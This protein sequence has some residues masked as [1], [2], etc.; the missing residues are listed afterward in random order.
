LSTSAH[1]SVRLLHIVENMHDQAVENWIFRIMRD[2]RSEHPEFHW[3]FY[4][5]LGKPGRLDD[6]VRALGGEVILSPVP[7]SRKW[8]FMSS[9]R[10]TML[11]GS[12]DVVHAHHDI[13]SA[14]YLA[15]SLGTPVKRRIVH[16]HNTS[17]SLPTPS[18]WK[19][20]LVRE[21]MRRTVL[22]AADTIAG[23][24]KDALA[25]MILDAPPRAGR[26]IVV[27]YG[28]DTAKFRRPKRSPGETRAQIHVPQD[29]R[30]ILFA[31]RM[32]EYKNPA[33]VVAMLDAVAAAMPDVIAV[34]AGVGLETDTVARRA[35][36]AGLSDRI[37]LLGW[38]D[39]IAELMLTAD[40]L[41]WPGQENPKEGLGLGIV[42]AQAA[43]LPILMSRSVPED[44]VVIPQ[45]ATVMPL[46]TGAEAWGREATR[47]L[48]RGIP[49]RE[50]SLGAIEASH[51]S[52]SAGT[53]NVMALYSNIDRG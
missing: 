20:A 40:L 26:D 52:L 53:S 15:A 9:L 47:I 38:R 31:G 1:K 2:S 37:R 27:Y 42:E 30:M 45:L 23:I 7:L 32:T 14:I 39:D 35:A 48:E 34:F 16:V 13:V 51:F 25:S 10:N 6:Q 24:S 43:G 17:M 3:T 4:S 22:A 12:Y 11:R 21:P 29:A 50:D 49:P 5:T 36:E 19:Q 44:A 28:I 41:V 46:S 8:K 33:F 18:P